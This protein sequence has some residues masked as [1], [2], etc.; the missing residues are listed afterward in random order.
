MIKT[1]KKV[2]SI[3]LVLI[4]FITQISPV[5]AVD[6]D[7]GINLKTLERYL[8]ENG[9][10]ANE[11]GV[12]SDEE[13]A[14]VKNLELDGSNISV[15]GIEKAINL[16]EL[17]ISEIN[18]SSIDFT[19]LT[20]LKYLEILNF[21][22][23][24]MNFSQ[25]N[26]I[27][28]LSIYNFYSSKK[29]DLNLSQMKQLER[30]YISDNF[31]Y[32]Y[33][34]ENNIYEGE[35]YNYINKLDISELSNLKSLYLFNTYC[36]DIKLSEFTN[37]ESICV[38]SDKELKIDLTNSEKLNF[39]SFLC[40]KNEI[41]RS[42][43]KIK[44]DMIVSGGK[45][46]HQ[47]ID[48]IKKDD[49]DNIEIVK[50]SKLYEYDYYLLGTELSIQDSKIL[51]RNE[52]SS[53]VAKEVGKEN[54]KLTDYWGREHYIS[55]TVFENNPDISLENT[56]ITSKIMN[57]RILKSNGELWKL[58]SETSAEKVDTNVKKYASEFVYSCR[59][60]VYVENILKNDDTLI[61]KSLNKEK[62]IS[63]VKD[64]NYNLFLTNN[65]DLYEIGVNYITEQINP[66][67]IQTN[68]KKITNDCVVFND[69]TTWYQRYWMWYDAN[70]VELEKLADFEIKA[71]GQFE[72]M[73]TIV[74]MNNTLWC[75]R[76]RRYYFDNSGLEKLQENFAGY[77]EE[78]YSGELKLIDGNAI[79]I[80]EEYNPETG[81]YEVIDSKVI[82]TNVTQIGDSDDLSYNIL[83]RTD[84]SIWT[85]SELKGLNK[86]TKSTPSEEEKPPVEED[87]YIKNPRMKEKEINGNTAICG[88]NKNKTVESFINEKN[89]NEQYI[90]KVFDSNNQEVKGTQVL[91]TGFK[92]KLYTDNTLVKEY[93]VVI[94]GDTTGDGQINAFDALTLIKGINN[95]IQFKG[96]I[97]KEAGRIIAG[98]GQTP[99]ALDALAIVKSANNKY[100]INQSK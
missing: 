76:S 27:E 94:Y 71:S 91:G 32:K 68:V 92:I 22:L 1:D 3:F 5:F 60:E 62:K 72:Y 58:N 37:I 64:V 39:A 41:N 70:N 93:V 15:S 86:I 38:A 8:I 81:E 28:V 66:K 98:S 82:L 69:N 43:I 2:I 99:T 59:K 100:T 36:C 44:E 87:K 21:D 20:N 65:G 80:K 63:N 79:L 67:K 56:G 25:L 78:R 31:P 84:G 77:T 35:T 45:Y 57:S 83:V 40:E 9:V 18:P 97:Y 19:K 90:V 24:D 52:D 33:D 74:D 7:T 89:F 50:G 73:A 10:D 49:L 42:D 51:E 12:L 16:K 4:I 85:Y 26:N 13:W 96:E 75:C 88:I 61:I 95:K 14:T 55:V 29:I 46:G 48:I 34:E 47:C 11:D 6:Y 17:R 23:S 54:I 53:I 30:L